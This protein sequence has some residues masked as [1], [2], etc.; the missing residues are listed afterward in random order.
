MDPERRTA[1]G[2]RVH[3]GRCRPRHPS[4]SAGHSGGIIS[5]TGGEALPRGRFGTSRGVTGSPAITWFRGCRNGGRADPPRP[6]RIGNADLFWAI[7]GGGGNF[8][9][10]VSL[11]FRLHPVTQF[12]PVHF[13]HWNKPPEYFGYSVTLCVT[14]RARSMLSL[15]S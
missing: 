14:L 4:R 12:T 8:G 5:T 13:V 15:H 10:A 7:R 6:T 9:I 1:E 3:L 2:R 11:E